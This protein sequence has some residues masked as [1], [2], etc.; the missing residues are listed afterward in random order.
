MLVESV[1]SCGVFCVPCTAHN[2][3]HSLKHFLPTLL[4]I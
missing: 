1:S 4:N 2:I 3:H